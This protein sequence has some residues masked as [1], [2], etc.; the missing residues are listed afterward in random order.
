LNNFI[1]GTKEVLH[2]PE[3]LT[4]HPDLVMQVLRESGD[5]CG[6]GAPQQILTSCPPERF[7]AMPTGEVCIYGLDEI[8]GMTQISPSEIVRAASDTSMIFS[9]E[10]ML[11]VFLAF[12]LGTVLGNFLSRKKIKS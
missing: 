8:H 9:P 3:I 4:K 7:C 2:M 1:I 11:T 6:M 10:V 5:K 12:V